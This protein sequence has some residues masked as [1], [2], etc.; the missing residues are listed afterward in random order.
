MESKNTKRLLAQYPELEMHQFYTIGK[1]IV[2][3]QKETALILEVTTRRLKEYRDDWLEEDPKSLKLLPLFNIIHAIDG[4]RRHVKGEHRE[5]E[6][7]VGKEESPDV[8]NWIEEMKK[9]EKVPLKYLPKDEIERRSS[10]KE[11]MVKD[12]KAKLITE[13]V[14]ESDKID[15]A[16]AE[17][18]LMVLSHLRT[19][20]KILP[21]EVN[22]ENPHIV[23]PIL[24]AE[25]KKTVDL[26]YNFT[27]I[28]IPAEDDNTF[29]DIN[30]KVMELLTQGVTPSEI[31]RRLDV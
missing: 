12:V 2:F 5:S 29:W 13:E 7:G 20:K 26:L 25:F 21:A 16:K 9:W 15:F 27:N 18:S 11:Y 10:A 28:E 22:P 6:S 4:Y 3:E 14:I 19:L 31:M 24:D 30:S 8:E 1:N 17:V 23:T